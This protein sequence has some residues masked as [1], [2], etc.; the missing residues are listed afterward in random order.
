MPTYIHIHIQETAVALYNLMYDSGAF[1]NITRSKPRRGLPKGNK[2]SVAQVDGS[3]SQVDG[4]SQ[5]LPPIDANK[6][7]SDNGQN[8]LSLVDG[9]IR[10]GRG[11]AGRQHWGGA[12]SD[13]S[14]MQAHAER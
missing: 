14:V 2:A 4:S 5:R 12:E 8:I 11:R 10:K 7:D 6:T 1:R 3:K 9:N 13:A